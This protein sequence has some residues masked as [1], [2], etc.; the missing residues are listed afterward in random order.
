MITSLP[1]FSADAYDEAVKAHVAL[2]QLPEF[3]L[4]AIVFV[5]GKAGDSLADQPFEAGAV[6]AIERPLVESL[7]KAFDLVLVEIAEPEQTPLCKRGS[8]NPSL[9]R[10]D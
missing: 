6:A 8:E 3:L 10:P 7:R 4:A 2:E 9:K 5:G 1:R